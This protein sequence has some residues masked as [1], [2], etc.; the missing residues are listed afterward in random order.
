LAD[1]AGG[2]AAQLAAHVDALLE[3][4]RQDA[5]QLGRLAETRIMGAAAVALAVGLVFSFFL[6]RAVSGPLVRMAGQVG[7]VAE[8]D[9]TVAVE[10]LRQQDEVGQLASAFAVM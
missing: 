7:R 4:A 5:V 10:R 1:E 9:V 6:T 2:L 8:G 3:Q